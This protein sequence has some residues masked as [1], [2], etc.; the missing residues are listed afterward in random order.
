MATAVYTEKD[1]TLQDGTDVTLKPLPIVQL[2]RF[3]S[4][5]KEVRNLPGDTEDEKEEY[6]FTIY[7][8][9]C[10]VSLENFFKSEE[11]FTE[12]RGKG[13]DPLSKEY[14][15]Y[16]ESVLDLETI[17]TILDVCGGLNL[18]DPKLA[19]AALAAAQDN[20]D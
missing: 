17:F 2:R 1:I 15:E 6:V 11:K 14:R 13:K 16:L 7:I 5:W 20:Q 12:L 19:A 9:C 3:M 10:G 4:L 18:T 8:N